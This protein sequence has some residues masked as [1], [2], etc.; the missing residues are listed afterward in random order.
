MYYFGEV[1]SRPKIICRFSCV[2]E[3][4][5]WIKKKLEIIFLFFTV[6]LTDTLSVEYYYFSNHSIRQYGTSFDDAKFSDIRNKSFC[7]KVL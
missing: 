4:P 1:I 6:L 7:R 5:P 3:R 2:L